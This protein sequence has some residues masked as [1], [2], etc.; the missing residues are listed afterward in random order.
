MIM[1]TFTA[2]SR[3]RPTVGARIRTL[4]VRIWNDAPVSAGELKQA[5]AVA[6]D[7]FLR[8][9]VNAVWEICPQ[10]GHLCVDQ[11]PEPVLTLKIVGPR[12]E[13]YIANHERMGV[14]VPASRVAYLLFTSIRDSAFASVTG[15]PTALAYV[16][17]H[18]TGHL[19]GL[20]H[21]WRGIME[22]DFNG[23]TGLKARTLELG[24]E[25]DEARMIRSHLP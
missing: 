24:F 23:L 2:A 16:M 17:V 11:I 8:A 3:S 21:N 9:G 7:I 18:E 19:L 14:A 12:H 10:K 1:L 25:D 4:S 20:K 5:F 6:G 13:Q 15:F 22:P